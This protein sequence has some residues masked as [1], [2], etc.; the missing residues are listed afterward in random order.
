[1]APCVTT[2]FAAP[3]E[4]SE[5]FGQVINVDALGLDVANAGYSFS[6]FPSA[7]NT[8][9]GERDQ[10]TLSALEGLVDLQLPTLDIPVIG[11]DGS[12]LLDLGQAGVLSSFSIAESATSARS[13]SGVLDGN[14]ALALDTIDGEL[15][16]VDLTNLFAQLGVAGLTD[17]V[18]STASLELGALGSSAKRTD[19][20]D[21]E[22]DYGLASATLDFESPAIKDLSEALT[23]TTT[24]LG[25]AVDGIVGDGGLSS[26]I[27]SALNLANVNLFLAQV[28]VSNAQLSIDGIDGVV[29]VLN[30]VLTEELVSTTGLVSINLGEGTIHVNLEELTGG[31]LNGQPAGTKLLSDEVA[32]QITTELTALLEGLTDKLETAL[33][34]VLS[35]ATFTLSAD[36]DAVVLGADLV[37]GGIN[38]SGSLADLL[39][40]RS[41]GFVSDNDLVL[42]QGLG[43][44]INVGNLLT[45]VVGLVTS[46][47][48]PIFSTVN[49]LISGL[50]GTVDGLVGDVVAPVIDQALEP[51]L[52][53]VLEITINKQGTI[54]S[55]EI[56]GP[57]ADAIAVEP[58]PEGELNYVTALS[59]EVLPGLAA[60]VRVDLGT[61]AVRA[62]AEAPAEAPVVITTPVPDQEFADGDPVVVSGTGEPGKTIT[63]TLDGDTANAKTAPVD[64]NGDWTQTFTAVPE[65]PHTV[66][67]TDG[68]STDDVSFSV[69][70]NAAENTGDNTIEN[71]ADNQ[72]DNQGDNTVENTADNQADNQG[73]N[74][75]DNTVENT[76]DNQ[77][78]NQTDNQGDNTVENT[79]DNQADNQTDNQGDNTVENTSDNQGD[80]QTDNQT[81]NT[82]ENTSDNQA[83]NQ[84]ENTG[85]NT[86][87]NTSDNQADNQG[88]NQGENTGD[89][90]AVN[91]SD[92][93]A[94][95]QGDNQGENTGE[96]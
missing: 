66:E 16:T 13:S 77:A 49:G 19:G 58:A 59:L 72:A 78:D 70:Q 62:A 40:G 88:D 14:G 23:G 69:T 21:P 9:N 2:A 52:E 64:E 36:V 63:V 86:A 38:L 61:S 22:L 92:N 41:A 50:P 51:L 53:G 73:D 28:G 37:N 93:Q 24:T 90:T 75:G 6:S 43:G 76:S 71:T 89:N 35:N 8:P 17:Q 25:N 65:G 31:D 94:D 67:A 34:D 44:G 79:S 91:T 39:T 45:T 81:D 46:T 15:A 96:N 11:E 95:N 82:V 7:P 26:Q 20:N 4:D 12:G 60:G 30:G 85:D 33:D 87:V 5:A 80:N 56:T 1:M 3:A 54:P 18:I 68:T 84:G 27:V 42:L 29:G 32:T 55:A 83:D 48:A 57:D 10:L 47:T 74:Q